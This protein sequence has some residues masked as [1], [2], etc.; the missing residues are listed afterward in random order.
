MNLTRVA[1]PIVALWSAASLAATGADHRLADAVERL[2]RQTVSALL[3]QR[4]DVNTPQADGA[5]ALAWA[6]HWNDLAT[7]DLLIRAGA[8]VNAANELGVTP[9]WL[10]C[11][12]GSAAMAEM[13]LRAGANSN[14]ALVGGETPILTAART[15]SAAVVKTLLAHGA[16]LN[17][18]KNGRGGQTPLMWAVA[19]G[20]VESAQALLEGGANV[21]ARST[22]GFTPLLFAA[23]IG[24]VPSIRALMA[25]GADVDL[26]APDG[27]TPLMMAI[28][29]N[30]E[31]AALSLLEHGADPNAAD[32]GYTA[33]H[34]AAQRAYLTLMKALLARGADPNP[35][36]TK[37]PTLVFGAGGGAGRADLT[38]ATPLLV[39]ARALHLD[40]VRLLLAAGGDPMLT[41]SDG[42]TPLMVAAGL[43]Q[44]EDTTTKRADVL[45]AA[46]EWEELRALETVQLLLQF[47][48]DVNAAN[49]LGNT[50]LHGAA[51]VGGNSVVRLLVANGARLDLQDANGQTPFRIAEGHVSGATFLQYPTTAA[52][53]RALG[54]NTSLGIDARTQYLTSAADPK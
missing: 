32:P 27:S 30:H 33:L 35:R 13:L 19:Q 46:I 7:A 10:A 37:A 50:A 39:A 40:T 34:A 18:R 2:D 49:K 6:A 51:Y 21:N 52:L 17:A 41:T 22:T 8:D 54:A 53:F 26:K 5:T 3:Q 28:A 38:G 29:S 31:A 11:E 9:L 36:L 48:Y 12:N 24:S 23:R 47:R 15:G 45:A 20:H 43:G 44:A 4:V 42:T 14:A 1:G 16:D 25:G